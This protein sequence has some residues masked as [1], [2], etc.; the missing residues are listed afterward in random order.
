MPL[1]DQQVS[2]RLLQPFIRFV[3][4]RFEHRSLVPQDFWSTP[5]DARVSCQR[6]HDMLDAGAEALRD[7]SLGLRLGRQMALGTGGAFDYTVRAAPTLRESLQTAANYSK[8]LADA[9]QISLEPWGDRLVVRLSHEPSWTRQAADFGMSAFYKLHVSDAVA[10]GDIEVWFRH[11]ADSHEVEAYELTFPGT[12]LQFGGPLYGFVIPVDV[13]DAPA[14]TGDARLH[15]LLCTRLDAMMTTI[16]APRPLASVVRRLIA[17]ELSAGHPS[18]EGVARTLHVSRRTLARRLEQEGT[19][20][21]VEYDRAR[22]DVAIVHVLDAKMSFSEAAFLSG[23]SHIESFY[24]AFKRWTGQTPGTYRDVNL[25][26]RLVEVVASGETSGVR[27]SPTA[28][29]S[30][31]LAPSPSLLRAK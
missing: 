22:R 30:S 18:A 29:P 4:T 26:N 23:F 8:L 10:R 13:A 21:E 17:D 15:G 1:A 12:A 6:A 5:Q 7:A 28:Q 27:L 24:R 2:A 20:F 25:G 11:E 9:F 31:L 3:S 14:A 19:S 16:T